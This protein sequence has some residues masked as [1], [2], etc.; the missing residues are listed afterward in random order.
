MTTKRWLLPEGVEEVLA[1]AS[2]RLEALRGRLLSL[3][4]SW[5]Y[6]L[7]VPPLIE[8][9]ESLLTGTGHDLDLQTFKVTDQLSG[10]LMGVR[11]DIT[12]QAARIDASRMPDDVPARLCYIG[13]VLRTRPES[14]GGS[15]SPLQVGIELFGHS[16]PASDMEV[17]SLML[18]SL[19]AAAIRNLHLDLGHVG[20]YRGLV[21]SAGLDAEGE[22]RLFDILQRKATADLEAFLEQQQPA[23]SVAAMLRSLIELNGEADVIESARDA[24]KGAGADVEAALDE[25]SHAVAWLREYHPGLPLHVDLAEL[26]GYSYHTGLV[27]A[28][29]VPG[30]GRELARGGRYDNVGAAFDRARPATGFSADL[31]QLAAFS[32]PPSVPE[33]DAA[34]YAPA[35]GDAALEQEIADLR[36]AGRRVVRAL[37]GLDP[38]PA[39]LGCT[40]TL[41]HNES[42][43]TARPLES[44]DH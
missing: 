22:R 39:A 31:A 28:A 18:A 27:Y 23:V 3:F 13:H 42:G 25:L 26:R 19:R 11:A 15:R 17:L 38:G 35:Q 34:V 41:I 7:V 36:R 12:P 14:L 21:S 44:D 9:L 2:W 30:R 43:W 29:F 32:E 8:Y 33:T 40:H 20:I 5:G 24:L 37:P 10:R 4:R 6:D 16:G 1:P